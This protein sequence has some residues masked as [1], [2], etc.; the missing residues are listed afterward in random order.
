MC[1]HVRVI[2]IFLA[3]ITSSKGSLQMALERGCQGRNKSV[4]LIEQH[5]D[6]F[7]AAGSLHTHIAVVEVLVSGKET[8]V[9]EGNATSGSIR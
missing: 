8:W 9:R 4:E 7:L 5:H 6:Q 1:S 3:S 2:P